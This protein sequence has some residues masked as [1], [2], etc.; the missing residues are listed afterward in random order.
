MADATDSITA[1]VEEDHA[2]LKA[3]MAS[4]AD[5]IE[6][7]EVPADFTAWK[8]ELLWQLRDFHNQLMKHF[9]LEEVGGFMADVLRMA[10]RHANQ[11]VHLEE[12]HRKIVSDL[13]HILAEVKRAESMASSQWRRVRVRVEDL[14]GVIRAHEAS[15]YEL[16]Q[17]VFYQDYG[18]GD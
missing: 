17:D 13:N 9:D 7:E 11:V 5:E 10:P 2:R 1:K 14:F 3:C 8:L 18:V 4:L 16:M 12:E 15:E 6:R